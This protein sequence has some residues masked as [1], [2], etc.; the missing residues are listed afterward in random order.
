M[1]RACWD[2]GHQR[3]IRT[4][5]ASSDSSAAEALELLVYRII[6]ELGSLVAALGGIDALVLTGGV[7]ENAISIRP[8]SAPVPVGWASIWTSRL[9]PRAN[10]ASAGPTPAYPPGLCPRMKE[11]MIARH[12]RRLL[13]SQ[14][15]A[16]RPSYWS[17][18]DAAVA[19]TVERLVLYSS[20]TS[21]LRS[22]S[23][24]APRACSS[25]GPSGCSRPRAWLIRIR[26]TASG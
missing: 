22:V 1:S 3:E 6:R 23:R 11:L 16:T 20:G 13:V 21:S 10:H 12:T 15:G 18:P 19:R 17:L 2:V 7:G 8:E 26:N 25:D 24:I 9:T 5:L 4:L 14:K